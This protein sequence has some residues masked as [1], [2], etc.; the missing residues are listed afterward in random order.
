ME[1]IAPDKI[2]RRNWRQRPELGLQP[3]SKN[4]FAKKSGFPARE[5]GDEI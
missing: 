4:V 3:I 1:L 2:H 5:K